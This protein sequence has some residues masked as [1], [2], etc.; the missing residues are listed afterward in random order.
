[1]EAGGAAFEDVEN[2]AAPVGGRVLFAGEATNWFRGATADGAFSS[3]IREA[4]RLLGQATV[5][6]R[7]LGGSSAA[8]LRVRE[9]LAARL[10][11]RSLG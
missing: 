5:R 6:V 2:L 9:R 10:E 8:L 4:K 1:M 3:G 11:R 7:P